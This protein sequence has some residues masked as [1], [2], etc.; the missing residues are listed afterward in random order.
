MG[1][2]Y[3]QPMKIGRIISLNGCV[4]RPFGAITWHNHKNTDNKLFQG[5]T[6]HTVNQGALMFVSKYIK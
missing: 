2:Y 6:L 5:R 3:K 1:K 4:G